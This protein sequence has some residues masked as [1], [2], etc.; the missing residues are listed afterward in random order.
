MLPNLLWMFFL[1]NKK[2]SLCL[3][4]GKMMKTDI[5]KY[6]MFSWPTSDI[7]F[8]YGTFLLNQM[9]NIKD[10]ST[11]YFFVNLTRQTL[12]QALNEFPRM[13]WRNIVIISTPELI[14]LARYWLSAYHRTSAVFES[15]CSL[16]T[17]IH[18]LRLQ[19]G[20]GNQIVCIK[21][22]QRNVLNQRDVSLLRY[23]LDGGNVMPLGKKYQRSYQTIYRWR[24]E[25][26]RKL[27]RKRPIL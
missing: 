4:N 22:R 10:T 8:G 12:R 19:F 20:T 13:E 14:P 2:E 7:Y 23:F 17:V 15:T 5:D 18:E 24:A 27:G 11:H 1:T 21:S 3:S 26:F 6:T 25:I 16:E 9:L